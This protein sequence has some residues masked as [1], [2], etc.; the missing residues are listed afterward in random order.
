MRAW[1]KYRVGSFTLLK[2]RI[3]KSG[4]AASASRIDGNEDRPGNQAS[5]KGHEDYYFEESHK[6]IC[7]EG[8][9][10]ED[11]F[12]IDVSEVLSPAKHRVTCTRRLFPTS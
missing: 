3:Y 5:D 4:F 11:I 6:Q 12:V 1:A 7:V 8:V 10:I 2:D 9:M